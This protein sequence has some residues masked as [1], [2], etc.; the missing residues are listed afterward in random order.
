MPWRPRIDLPALGL[1]LLLAVGGLY[2]I[3]A[4]DVLHEGAQAHP[5][6]IEGGELLLWAAAMLLVLGWYGLHQQNER[7][8]HDAR[9]RA[10]EAR[11]ALL[12][13]EDP[14]TGIANRAAAEEQLQLLIDA[15]LAADTH[16][17][18]ILLELDGLRQ[19]EALNGE[20][21]ARAALKVVARRLEAAV[22]LSDL[23]ARVDAAR[24]AVLLPEVAGAS[25]AEI[26]ARRICGAIEAPIE[27]D[28]SQHRVQARLGIA[29]DTEAAGIDATE[30]LRRA[31]VA[32]HAALDDRRGTWRFHH[33]DLERTA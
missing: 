8:A 17:A 27:I 5:A 28:G 22:R 21:T 20:S 29:L 2:A 14:L 11:T 13:H 10:A 15:P 6:R 32:L 30:L 18:V 24:F 1:P 16:I 7:R 9:Q 26:V 23:A 31:D 4:L 33:A 12:G 3:W 25:A 19:I